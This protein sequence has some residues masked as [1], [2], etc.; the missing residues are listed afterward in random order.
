M[1]NITFKYN[2]MISIS[3]FELLNTILLPA[4][5]DEIPP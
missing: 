5:N 2:I 1:I 3:T 4:F